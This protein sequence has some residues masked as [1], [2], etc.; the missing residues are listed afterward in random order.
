MPW[1]AKDSKSKTHLADTPRRK[2]LWASV[3]NAELQRHGNDA[4]AIRVANSVIRKD[5][6]AHGSKD[7]KGASSHWSGV[8]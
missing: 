7:P 8:K 5:R 1:S 3:A 6:E 2:E 4:I